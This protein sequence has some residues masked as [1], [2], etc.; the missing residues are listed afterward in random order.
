MVKI[1]EYSDSEHS[2]SLTKISSS[3]GYPGAES[4]LPL[5]A[6]FDVHDTLYKEAA[7]SV[8]H[9]GAEPL[10]PQKAYFNVSYTD[11]EMEGMKS[12]VDSFLDKSEME[13]KSEEEEKPEMENTSA[14]SE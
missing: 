11:D 10:S 8:G 2:G 12:L 9:P 13:E 14:D 6:Y 5:K 4:L 1:V 7:S 3:K